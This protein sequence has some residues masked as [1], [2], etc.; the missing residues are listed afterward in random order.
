MESPKPE[1]ALHA[2]LKTLDIE[3]KTYRHTPVFT[4][5]DAQTARISI[6]GGMPGAHTKNLF[7]RDKKKRRALVTLDENRKVDLHTLANQIGLGRLSFGSADSL[8]HYLGVAPGSVT[9]LA[10]YNARTTDGM[11][12]PLTF[13]LDQSL[14]ASDLINV[15]PL[16]NTA[17]IAITPDDLM[18]FIHACGFH[19]L[20]IDFDSET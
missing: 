7:V 10:L 8:M 2:F 6:V 9:P 5:E 3:V 12:P 13:V 11:D 15:H 1:Q 20:V 16:H 14:L 19:P 17:T 4:V 18:R